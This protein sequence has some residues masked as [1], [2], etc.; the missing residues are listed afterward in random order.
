M[1]FNEKLMSI[2]KAKGLANVFYL[3]NKKLKDKVIKKLLY[4]H[5]RKIRPPSH[6]IKRMVM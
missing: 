5:F 2:R 4:G 3:L 1:K 6:F